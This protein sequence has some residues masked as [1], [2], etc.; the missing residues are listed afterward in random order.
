MVQFTVT[1]EVARLFER[2]DEWN[3]ETDRPSAPVEPGSALTGDDRKLPTLVNSGEAWSGFVRS[4]DNLHA[5]K[6]LLVDARVSHTF[7]PYSL[8]RSSIDNASATVW[9]LTPRQRVERLRRRLRLAH[10]D[11]YES[12]KIQKLTGQQ[13][14]PPGRPADVR[15][16]EIKDLARALR[17]DPDHICGRP[18]G[19]GE[20]VR[21][22][23]E[24]SHLGSDPTELIWRLCSGFAHGRTWAA[25]AYLEREEHS[26]RG[27]IV[28]VK[29]SS[30]PEQVLNLVRAAA[31]ITA[32]GRRLYE[33]RRR[34]QI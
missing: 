14:E 17:L 24:A 27:N 2:I 26:R 29:F 12:G 31:V 9:L 16:S 13:P 32:T 11:A 6:T 23:A 3:A 21:M 20:I 34:S 33:I 4:V 19:Y 25:V 10:L 5:V 15:I 22:A 18:Q 1:E 28:Q 8:I 7:A 30:S